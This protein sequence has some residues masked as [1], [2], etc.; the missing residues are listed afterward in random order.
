MTCKRRVFRVCVGKEFAAWRV[1]SDLTLEKC[2][3][4][5]VFKGRHSRAVHS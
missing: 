5:S 1:V 2:R 3:L 4:Y